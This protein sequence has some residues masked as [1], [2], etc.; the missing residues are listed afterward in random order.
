MVYTH[1]C[2]TY[3]NIGELS[4]SISPFIS[5]VTLSDSVISHC[6]IATAIK[7]HLNNHIV[8]FYF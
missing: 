4:S 6:L 2:R 5:M 7:I 8:H 3:Q 1:F